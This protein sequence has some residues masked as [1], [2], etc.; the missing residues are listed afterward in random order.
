MR[1]PPDFIN[2]KK[3]IRIW[4]IRPTADAVRAHPDWQA[5]LMA[6]VVETDENVFSPMCTTW[7]GG[8]VHLRDVPG[9]TKPASRH[10]PEAEYE[11]TWHAIDPSIDQDWVEYYDAQ[12]RGEDRPGLGQLLQPPEMVY[13]WAG[14][15]DTQAKDLCEAFLRAVRDGT[16]LDSPVQYGFLAVQAFRATWDRLLSGTVDHYVKG[17]HG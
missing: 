5:G 2:E 6:F 1:R 14:T 4:T 15:T 8:L 11:L 13:Q 3:G 12:A 17:I 10:F 9:Q 16:N 7:Y